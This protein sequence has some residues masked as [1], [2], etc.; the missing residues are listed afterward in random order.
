MKMGKKTIITML[1]LAGMVTTASA[2]QQAEMKMWSDRH[3]DFFERHT[4]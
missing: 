4:R 1:A 3:A 2:Q